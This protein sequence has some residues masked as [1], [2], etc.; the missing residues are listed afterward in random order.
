MKNKACARKCNGPH[1]LCAAYSGVTTCPYHIKNYSQ[2]CATLPSGHHNN[3]NLNLYFIV[4]IQQAG[5]NIFMLYPKLDKYIG[6][7]KNYD[8]T[9]ILRHDY[10]TL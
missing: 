3:C 1:T 6:H 10:C 8:M 2:W 9:E 7:Y 4:I 5:T